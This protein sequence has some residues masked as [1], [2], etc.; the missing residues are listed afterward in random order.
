MATILPFQSKNIIGYWTPDT[1]VE[2][3]QSIKDNYDTVV[4]LVKETVAHYNSGN[5]ASYGTACVY[6]SDIGNMCAVGRCL[7]EDALK[8]F[9]AVEQDQSFG[10]ECIPTQIKNE[11]PCF[12]SMFQ[13]KYHGVHIK[14]WSAMQD[15]HDTDEHWDENGLTQEG[16]NY[17]LT[18]FGT[19]IYASVFA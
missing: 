7:T 11:Y 13:E 2:V 12:D 4:S 14:V 17:I 15:L 6:K 18:T 16:K 8:V 5:R 3:R 19:E 1:L 10:I 9:H